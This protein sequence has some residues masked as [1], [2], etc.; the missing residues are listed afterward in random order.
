MCWALSDFKGPLRP[1]PPDRERIQRRRIHLD[2]QALA[3]LF[4]AS[5]DNLTAVFRAHAFEEAVD[6]LAAPVVRL[7]ST[8]HASSSSRAAARMPERTRK[9][10]DAEV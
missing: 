10:A 3:A 8:F 4:P 7:E 5:G 9:L 1:G 6:A 2:G